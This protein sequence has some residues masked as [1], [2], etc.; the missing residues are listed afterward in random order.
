MEEDQELQRLNSLALATHWEEVPVLSQYLHLKY[1]N[2]NHRDQEVVKLW[3]V[4]LPN[5]SL[6][7][8]EAVQIGTSRLVYI[9]E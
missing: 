4:L 8:G 5:L 7:D 3:V 6:L 9:L 2:L 1:N